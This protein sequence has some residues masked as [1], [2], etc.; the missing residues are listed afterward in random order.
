MES[1]H[2][3]VRGERRKL[4]F[5]FN[6]EFCWQ[7]QCCAENQLRWRT[8]EIFFDIRAVTEKYD[9]KKIKPLVGSF[10]SIEGRLLAAA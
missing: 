7:A 3:R 8:L 6:D 5:K 1:R 9:W 10:I 4:V 2:V